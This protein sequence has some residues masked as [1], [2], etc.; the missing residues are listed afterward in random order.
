MKNRQV[1]AFGLICIFLSLFQNSAR[2]QEKSLMV[3]DI[4]E[5]FIKGKSYESSAMT[6]IDNVNNLVRNFNQDKIIYIKSAGK[7]LAI[8]LKGVSTDTIPAPDFDPRLNIVN[9]NIFIKVS[10]GD[11]FS[12]TQLINFLENKEVKDI[13]I[14]GLLA[15][16]CVYQTALGGQARG[17]N[18]YLIPEAITGKS[19]KSKNKVLT[20]LQQKGIKIISSKELI[21]L[22]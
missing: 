6:M 20:K 21:N 10:T 16:K 18:I 12:C 8:S 2:S 4:Q 5:K 15:E 11:A 22:P 7:A 17:Y 13:V 3:L 14:I 1:L 9:D 19:E